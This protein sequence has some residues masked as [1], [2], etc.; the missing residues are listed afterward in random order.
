[1]FDTGTLVY[2]VTRPN[3]RQEYIKIWQSDN[4][5][6]A[7]CCDSCIGYSTFDTVSLSQLD[8]GEM[9]YASSAGKY[10]SL[11]DALRDVMDFAYDGQNVSYSPAG[12]D[13]AM[14]ED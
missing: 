11:Y 14:L 5:A 3:G 7:L 2:K 10:A 12:I 8:G 4:P 6:A 13:P 1:M 9:D